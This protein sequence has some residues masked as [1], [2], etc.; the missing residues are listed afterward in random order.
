MKNT[1]IALFFSTFLAGCVTSNIQ[2]TRLDNNK[3]LPQ[4]HGI[5]AVQV[6][7][8]AERLATWH[9]GWTEV[10]AIRLDNREELKQAAIAKAREK[11]KGKK[12]DSEN[13][14]WDVEAYSLTALPEG[15]ID[16][17]MFVGSMP[18]GKY[19]ISSLYSFYSDGNLSS[20]VS[21]P[22][23]FSAGT[24]QVKDKQ[25]TNLG[26]LVFQPLL[27]I[28]KKSFWNNSSTQKA[29]VTRVDEREKLATFVQSHYPNLAKDVNFADV[30]QW[31][32]DEDISEYRS[33]LG[34]ISRNNAYGSQGISLSKHAKGA[35]AAKFGQLRVLQNDDTWLQ[36]DL[37]TNGQIAAILEGQDKVLIAGER[38]QVFVGDDLLGEWQSISPVSAK[39]ALIWFGQGAKAA[40]ALSSSAKDYRLYEL[41]S[42]LL[43]WTE[44]G[45]FTKKKANDFWVQNGGIFPLITREKTIR[46]INDNTVYDLD[47]LSKEWLNKKGRSLVDMAQLNDGTLL[48]LDV[49]QWDGVGDQIVSF[50]DG[51]T[52]TTIGRRLNIFSDNKTE[53]TL[54]GIMADGTL[55]SLGRLK[56]GEGLK[57]I[58]QS[59]AHIGEKKAWQAH[60]DARLDCQTLLPELSANK[61][62]YFLCE[63]GQIVATADF[64]KSW[65]TEVDINLQQM[66][67]D[68]EALL[69][70]L[71]TQQ[72]L[73]KEQEQEGKSPESE[74]ADS[75]L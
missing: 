60:G 72:D 18:Q 33:T 73:E 70:A 53:R 32:Q 36:I 34:K 2:S 22:V 9:K 8:N 46:V 61:I 21:I 67:Q 1:L 39:E 48:A 63:Q 54:P 7:N 68:Y 29:Y 4:G 52:W 28:K 43:T 5:V 62:L 19:L 65:K 35:V 64:G 3:P 17:Q 45:R 75:T 47:P 13:V 50:D 26:S 59:K 14:D 58:T 31:D 37:P 6:I 66:Q 44:V 10:I 27:S 71:K 49:S 56:K 30:L 16:S 24:Y 15:L 51:D 23:Y 42:D 38:G 41:S 12:I 69:E 74:K 55:V 57:I 11:A 25:F 20:W 40:Y